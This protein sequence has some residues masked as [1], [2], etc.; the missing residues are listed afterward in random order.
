MRDSPIDEASPRELRPLPVTAA[1]AMLVIAF[2][3]SIALL[4]LLAG[5]VGVARGV[6]LGEA[7]ARVTANPLNLS[8]AQTFGIGGA[9]AAGLGWAREPLSLRESLRLHP[10]SPEI[11]ALAIIAGLG[12]QFPLAELGNLLERYF[13]IPPEQE[14]FL[15]RLVS[16]D[17]ILEGLVAILA[18]VVLPPLGEEL[19]FRGFMLP[20][21]ERDRGALFAIAASAILFGLSHGVP[22]AIVYAAAA[23]VVLGV[24]ARRTGS[25]LPAIAMHAAVNAVPLLLPARVV[26]I[27]GFNTAADDVYH[28]PLPLMVG[29]AL[30]ATI[31][32]TAILRTTPKEP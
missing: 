21:L 6:A 15:Q 22:S 20:R 18:V 8:F 24:I 29:G 11:I 30:L 7:W 26:S 31:A 10:V 2:V 17:T 32:C 4:A 23:G 27:P 12:L 28:V 3:L 9:I 19:L 1:L 5:G 14:L 25:T 16:P 13:P